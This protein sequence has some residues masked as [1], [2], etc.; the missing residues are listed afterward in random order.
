MI[1]FL[2]EKYRA[3]YGL[4]SDASIVRLVLRKVAKEEGYVSGQAGQ[5][6]Q[7]RPD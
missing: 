4:E 7:N 6:R 2:K 5:D 3:N 1:A